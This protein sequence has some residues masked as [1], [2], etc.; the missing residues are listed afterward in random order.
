[1]RRLLKRG[2]IGLALLL[3]LAW[4]ASTFTQWHYSRRELVT[5]APPTVTTNRAGVVYTPLGYSI[6]LLNV[7]LQEGA[8]WC[9]RYEYGELVG[10][11]GNLISGNFHHSGPS[12]WRWRLL[13]W[14][15]RD[16]HSTLSM[17]LPLWIPFLM[18]AIP[19]GL[20]WWHDARLNRLAPEV[21]PKRQKRLR[22]R[23]RQLWH[24]GV[25]LSVLLL[26]AWAAALL[27]DVNCM[28]HRASTGSGARPS[29]F[30]LDL[31]SG[32]VLCHY[33]GWPA[34][35]ALY[36]IGGIDPPSSPPIWF[37][38]YYPP[39]RF[40]THWESS[41]LLPLW[42]PLLLS[43]GL[44]GFLFWRDR[45]RVSPANCCTACGYDLT[46]NASGVCPECGASI[47]SREVPSEPKD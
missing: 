14:K 11:A 20:F 35:P 36:V 26:V 2:S 37:P 18:V 22:N 10:E 33:Y 40:P 3:L 4:V 19:A 32:C 41:V 17:I 31:M 7:W 6:P 21:A 46:G 42:I 30:A 47:T 15:D 39:T 13:R 5:T 8:L 43:V 44:T 25:I 28:F 38:H 1:M 16:P 34:P 12:Q 24:A 45:R 9:Y 29:W 23:T 27:R